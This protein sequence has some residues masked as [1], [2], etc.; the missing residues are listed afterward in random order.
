MRD[1]H[2]TVLP[3]SVVTVEGDA[4]FVEEHNAARLVVALNGELGAPDISYYCFCFDIYGMGRKIVS[5][6]IYGIES[7]APATKSGNT[8]ICP[9]PEV[10]TSTGELFVQIEAHKAVGGECQRVVKSGMFALQFEPSVTGSE[11][12]LEEECGLLP[13]LRAVLAGIEM[14]GS[15]V[16]QCT[17]AE[18]AAIP[19]KSPAAFYLV[20]DD[21][22]PPPVE[23]DNTIYVT[24]I[25]LNKA[26]TSITTGNTETLTAA[27]AP[28]NATNKAVVW[29]SGNTAAATV[30]QSGVVTAVSAGSAVITATT[31]D[32]AF[33]AACNVTVSVQTFAVTGV[34]L[35]KSSTSI[36]VGSTETLTATI[37]P[38]NASN[39][40]VVWSS[41]NTAAATVSQSGVVTAVSAGSA[42]I[43][44]TTADG[45]FSAA[46]A[47]TIAASFPKL[48]QGTKTVNGITAAVSGS[49]VTLNGTKNT[50]DSAGG[51]GYLTDNLVTLFTVPAAWYTFAGGTQISIIVSNKTGTSNCNA[52]NAACVL[53]KTDNT[54]LTGATWGTPTGTFT[55]TC[56]GSTPVYGL[57]FYVLAG[58]VIT[59]YQ[60]DVEFWVN[61][62]RWI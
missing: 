23:T 45:G 16:T 42:A 61:G 6:N 57:L 34:T 50:N 15:T 33:S 52:A 7:D 29:S 46:C 9:L 56:S 62:I 35:N 11:E 24:G 47:V 55:Y 26:S 60:F 4:G 40:A 5:N 20:E 1:I 39:K 3:N 8:L 51:G 36:T 58:E 43:T 2:A 18:Y 17:A 13:R 49:H 14:P 37:A 38:S 53:R 44:V 48:W 32:G 30:S 12:I 31:A 28:A 25:A 54:I 27:V 10:L 41:G 59:N 21:E 22:T 19:A